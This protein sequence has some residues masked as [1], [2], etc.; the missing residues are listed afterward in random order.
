MKR[1]EFR[2]GTRVI[3]RSGIHA[4]VVRK[5][6]DA[7]LI[8]YPQGDTICGEWH[9]LDTLQIDNRQRRITMD[10]HA[11]CAACGGYWTVAEVE[12]ATPG[13]IPH[14]W[15]SVPRARGCVY[16]PGDRPMTGSSSRRCMRAWP[17]CSSGTTAWAAGKRRA[18]GRQSGGGD[19]P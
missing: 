8:E 5:R 2:P 1:N 16:P 6:D 10:P 11:I 7:C 19:K 4:T 18:G 15:A 9:R 17:S 14:L 3:T 12:A 13:E